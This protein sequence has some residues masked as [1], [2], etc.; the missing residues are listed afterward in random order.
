MKR[1]GICLRMMVKR[2][3]KHPVYWVLLLLFPTALFVVP[4]LN[5]AADEEQIL[6]GYV[7]EEASEGKE[8]E[9]LS[10][11]PAG[12]SAEG[13]MLPDGSGES[14]AE[15]KMLPEQ[16]ETEGIR[17]KGAEIGKLAYSIQL[18]DGI[19][20]KLQEETEQIGES[21]ERSEKGEG[22]T[23]D[24]IGSSRLFQYIKY[25]EIDKMKEDVMTGELSCGIVFD[26]DFAKRLAEQ[27]YRHC[28]K[29]YLPE[30]MNVGGMVQ[31]DVFARVYQAYS[32]V[33]YAEL[34]EQQGYQ[35][36]P[37]EVLQKFSEYQKEGK[38]FA[39]EYEEYGRA[40]EEVQNA[41]GS[42]KDIS[43]VLSVRSVLAF[44]TF[45]SASLGA[46]DGGRD[47]KRGAGKGICCKKTLAAAAAGA[48]VLP[49]TLFLAAGMIYT[50]IKTIGMLYAGRAAGPADDMLGGLMQKTILPELCSAFVYGSILWLLAMCFGRIVPEKL[51]EGIMPC[52]LLITVLCCPV[53]F[54]LGETIPVIDGLSKL[55]PVTWYLEF[56][57]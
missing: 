1:A 52:F 16:A 27:D 48:P 56:W 45:L 41:A 51:L 31:E 15:G 30:G 33:W 18:L 4:R 54:D 3:G 37:E 26:K 8:V 55:F 13:R 14:S 11:G 12:S 53:F 21:S 17:Q 28:I 23:S 50:D 7:M 22:N 5:K 36:T 47:R 43:A 6:V 38:V 39:V 32:A 40:D 25:T 42:G 19:E 20:Y 49:S 2:M 24:R 9:M 34:L 35:I 44:L 29:L 57:G 46:L 10:N